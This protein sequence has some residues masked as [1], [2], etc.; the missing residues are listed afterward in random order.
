MTTAPFF[1]R[2]YAVRSKRGTLCGLYTRD[3]ATRIARRDGDEH[4]IVAFSCEPSRPDSQAFVSCYAGIEHGDDA[5][6]HTPAPTRSEARN[7]CSDVP[8]VYATVYAAPVCALWGENLF[9]DTGVSNGRGTCKA[10]APRY[11]L[12]PSEAAELR[13]IWAGMAAITGIASTTLGHRDAHAQDAFW[14][15]IP[16]AVDAS[17]TAMMERIG[18][19]AP[20][21]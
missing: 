12:T 7:W 3:R 19:L 4:A 15:A 8:V 13:S 18:Q 11:P 17:I 5:G 10:P 14:D 21:A 20:P 16:K 2:L 9:V 1:D 6:Y